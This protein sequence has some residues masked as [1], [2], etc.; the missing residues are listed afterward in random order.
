MAKFW[1]LSLV[2]PCHQLSTRM[3]Y[4][5]VSSAY[6]QRQVAK[7]LQHEQALLPAHLIETSTQC[8]TCI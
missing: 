3:T 7:E 6:S 4:K 1:S 5:P 2:I 8:D